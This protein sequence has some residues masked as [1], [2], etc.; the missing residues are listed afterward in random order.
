MLINLNSLIVPLEVSQGSEESKEYINQILDN[1]IEHTVHDKSN[2]GDSN[3][4]SNEED[5]RVKL[6]QHIMSRIDFFG[7]NLGSDRSLSPHMKSMYSRQA[8]MMSPGEYQR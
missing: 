3:I 1:Y 4:G 2:F 6:K 8:H 7:R 5:E